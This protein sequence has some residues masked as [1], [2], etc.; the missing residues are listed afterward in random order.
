MV[1]YA[2]DINIIGRSK[3]TATDI[4]SGLEEKAKE[5]ELVVKSRKKAK[6]MI[7]KKDQ[8]IN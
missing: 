4:Y 2:D 1:K 3:K 8:I 5:D 7:Q 6:S